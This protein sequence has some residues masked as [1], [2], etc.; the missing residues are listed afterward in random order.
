MAAVQTLNRETLQ[1]GGNDSI[2]IVK[3]LADLPGGR[4]LDTSAFT[5]TTS[6]LHAGHV[7]YRLNDDYKPLEVSGTAYASIPSGATLIGVLK[8]PIL[9]SQGGAAIVTIGQVLE[10]ALPY[11]VTDEI[12][13]ALPLIQF[14]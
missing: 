2:V 7:I 11:P 4:T 12:K 3:A 14:I 5:G 9:V 6:T 13:E 8:E 10:G 1:I